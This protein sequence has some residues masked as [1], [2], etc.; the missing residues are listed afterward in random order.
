MSTISTP[1]TKGLHDLG[2]GLYAYLQPD[3]SWGWSNAG[4]VVDG[5]HSLLVDTLFDLHL[6]REML[7]TM[8]DAAPA[9]KHIDILFNT[10]ANG[11]HW[12]GNEAV[13][14]QRLVATRAAAEEMARL[15]AATMLELER[16]L[17]GNAGAF[18]RRVFAPFH[19]EGV[20][21]AYPT[22][23]FEST[24]TLEVG[25]REVQ[26]RDLGPA[27]T[28]SD[29]IVWVPSTRTVF[30]GDLLF[31]GAHP[32][33]WTGPI[34]NWMAALEHLLA[35]DAEAYVPGHG[36]LTDKRGIQEILDYLRY[37]REEAIQGQAAGRDPL[38][39]ARGLNLAPWMG[40]GESER[41][42][43]TVANVYRAIDPERPM[44]SMEACWA[45]MAEMARQ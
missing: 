15:P 38:Q 1:N 14:T 12:Y 3:G 32:I 9:A 39:V 10:H 16:S 8:A 24:L 30:T 6:T 42:A 22:E 44:P 4:L 41:L 19:F 7:R 34:E 36:P 20:G 23:Q 43:V 21:A 11:D 29:S 18:M 27:H 35:L 45:L 28:G 40:W 25:D 37:V 2:D 17:P 5:D 31:V 13:P 33:M 26:L